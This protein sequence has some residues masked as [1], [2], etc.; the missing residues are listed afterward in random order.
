MV[1]KKKQV[2]IVGAGMAGLTTAAYLVRGNYQVTLI[3]KTERTG[4]M[5]GTFEK[6]RFF[7]D[8][9]PRALINSGIIKPILADLDIHPEYL[10]NKISIG[11]EDQL[12]TVN[13]ID[14]LQTYQQILLDLYPGYGQDITQIIASIRKLSDYTKVLYEF[15][16]PN[17]TQELMK[18]KDYVFK[19]LLPWLVRFLQANQKL[20]R[21]RMPMEEFMGRLTNNLSITDV[22]TQHFFKKTPTYFALGYFYVYLDYFY[23]KGG[24][25][26]L[27]N[28][29]TEKVRSAGADIKL[30]KRIIEVIPGESRVIDS[31]GVSYSYDHL[32]W[33]ADLKTFYRSLNSSGLAPKVEHKISPVKKRLLSSKGAESVFMICLGV[34]RPPSYFQA[35]GGEHF[36]FTPSRMG[37]QEINRGEKADL[38]RNFNRKTKAEVL[39]WLER[40]IQ[41]NTYEI[42]VPVLR[43]QSMA[44]Q[45]QTGLMVSCL[46]DY[47]FFEK[48]E[49]AGWYEEFKDRVES[50]ICDQLSAT[51][52]K[53]LNQDTLFRFSSSPLTINKLSGS[54]EGAITGWTFE[55]D[56]P[57]IHSLGDIPKSVETPIPN[58][59][60]VGQW[61]YSPA[62][63]PIAMLTGWYAAQRLLKLAKR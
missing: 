9:G 17:V 22:I 8:T 58:I 24:T 25:G 53:D 19:K 39:T 52:F 49:E 44:P 11:I 56:P 48:V 47:E 63:V 14:D 54:S 3:E 42:S 34:N 41:R 29:L 23:P 62:G 43:D 16:N 36:F 35:R 60:Q 50:L 13:S 6:N 33:A 32:V 21:H 61:V 4:G 26:T 27:S 28:L 30:N 37:L 40:Y 10:K 20:N 2:V 7:F 57:V 5:V 15:D 31:D 59:Y 1:T 46:F 12:L 38:I 55:Q 51:I 18:D 45:G